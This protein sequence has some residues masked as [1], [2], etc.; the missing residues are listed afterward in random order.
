MKGTSRTQNAIRNSMWGIVS[1][2]LHIVGPFIFRSF[3]IHQI[4][5]EYVGLN[6]LF[7]SILSVLNMTE[8]GFA[9][10]ITFMMYKAVAEND[11]EELSTL[12]N[13]MRTVYRIV[14]SIVLVLGVSVF[15]VLHLL[16]DN[17]TGADVNI[18]LLYG[19]Y[20]FHTVMSYLMFA[21]RTTLFSA[22]QRRDI[23]SKVAC[24][25]GIVQYIAQFIV[26]LTTHNYYLYLLVYSLLIIPQSC[27]YYILSRKMYPSIYCKGKVSKNHIDVLKAK[28][29]PLLGHRIGGTMIISVDSI[30]LSACLGVGVL[31]KYDNYYLIFSTI[32]S[33]LTGIRHSIMASIGNKLNTDSVDSVYSVFKDM[34]FLWIGIIAWCSACLLSLFQPFIEMWLGKEY[35]YDMP[36]VTCFVAYF[37]VWQFRKMGETVKD[38]AGLW[39]QDKVKPYTGVILNVT[40]SIC[41]VSVMQHVTGVLIPTM[42]VLLLLYLPWETH[43]LFKWLFKRNVKEYLFLLM[44]YVITAVVSICMTYLIVSMIP[45]M[46]KGSFVLKALVSATVPLLW[47]AVLNCRTQQFRNLVNRLLHKRLSK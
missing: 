37:F 11:K 22:H 19:M 4:G 38:A 12:L 10:A 23:L 3:I 36:T 41:A 25:I 34:S 29:L 35:L 15:P 9:S 21:Y 39:E 2:L 6:S 40:L 20:L 47:Y 30:V 24:I 5:A 27:L 31:A 18:Y 26:L 16:V 7:K 1:Q 44:R 43:V 45:G 17:Q 13:L 46:G 8:L 28:I 14:G 33:F 42:F 32:A